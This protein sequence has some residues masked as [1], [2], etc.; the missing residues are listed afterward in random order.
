MRAT[1]SIAF[2]RLH[3]LIIVPGFMIYSDRKTIDHALA[4]ATLRFLARHKR[5]IEW[6]P[7]LPLILAAW[8]D[9]DL[10]AKSARSQEHIEWAHKHDVLDRFLKFLLGL[11]E[12]AW[13]HIWD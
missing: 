5:R 2:H 9:T 6:V 1:T 3:V 4:V 10:Q 12:S 11:P 8:W 13:F 7:T